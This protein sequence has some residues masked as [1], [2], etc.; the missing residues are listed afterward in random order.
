MRGLKQ[1]AERAG[2]GI[3]EKPCAMC[4]GKGS[5][6]RADGLDLARIRQKA[7]VS[8]YLFARVNKVSP[9]FVS[10]VEDGDRACPEAL[11][12]GYLKLQSKPPRKRHGVGEGVV[13]DAT[14]RLRE[15]NTGRRSKRERAEKGQV[16]RKRSGLGIVQVEVVA[17]EG[18]TVVVRRWDRPEGAAWAISAKNFSRHYKN[19]TE[20]VRG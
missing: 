1:K 12:A 5:F 2:V 10:M 6:L 15:A 18:E 16:W 13:R 9:G 17:V 3:E 14:E 4:K 8:K 19:V 7:G 11:L 20:E